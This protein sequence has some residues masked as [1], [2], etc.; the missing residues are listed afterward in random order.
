MGEGGVLDYAGGTVVHINAGVAG[1]VAA[2]ALGKRIGYGKEAM[3][4]HNMALT[5]TGAAML[6]VG[7]FGFNRRLC[8]GGRCFCRHGHGGYPNR[9]CRCRTHLAGVRENFRQPPF[10]LGLGFSAVAGLVG[11]TPG[12]RLCGPARCAGHRRAHGCGC[13]LGFGDSETQTGLR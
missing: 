13:I 4:P 7:W 2:I 3:P 8:G 11:I 9:R 6:W 12:S 1:L 10:R 5:L